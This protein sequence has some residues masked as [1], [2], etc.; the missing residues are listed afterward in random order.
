MAPLPPSY[1]APVLATLNAGHFADFVNARDGG[2]SSD[3][4]LLGRGLIGFVRQKQP[5]DLEFDRLEGWNARR[6][7]LVVGAGFEPRT[8]AQGEGFEYACI[9]NRLVSQQWGSTS[10]RASDGSACRSAQVARR[11]AADDMASK[12][13]TGVASLHFSASPQEAAAWHPAFVLAHDS[14]FARWSAAGGRPKP[15]SSTAVAM[16]AAF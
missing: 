11:G 14:S 9:G 5:A 6:T 8:V 10:A 7:R 4:R 12:L 3:L 2:I 13:S 16:R 15:A 1:S